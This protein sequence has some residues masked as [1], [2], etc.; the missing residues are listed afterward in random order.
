MLPKYSTPSQPVG[1][2]GSRPA[3]TTSY[4]ENG[5]NNS[6]PVPITHTVISSGSKL[7]TRLASAV[8]KAQHTTDANISELPSSGDWPG[9]EPLPEN[10]IS[11]PPTDS[12]IPNQR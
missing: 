2:S 12:A 9:E 4:A 1:G 11:T 3:F 8:Y 7:E 6:V 5:T 10:T